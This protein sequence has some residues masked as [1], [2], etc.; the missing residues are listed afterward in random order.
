MTNFYEILFVNKK[1]LSL[2]TFAIFAEIKFSL[3]FIGQKSQIRKN[4]IL[5]FFVRNYTSVIFIITNFYKILNLNNKFLL[6][7]TFGIIAKI[8][9]YPFFR[10]QNIKDTEKWRLEF[11][12]EKTYIVY[13]HIAQF[14]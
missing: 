4:N 10:R 11:F 14:S 1:I 7:A 6:L 13:L 5:N 9:F 8:E 3:F 12:S 2:A